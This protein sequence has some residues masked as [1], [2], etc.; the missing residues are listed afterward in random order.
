MMIN[1]IEN[2][3]DGLE[4]IYNGD[5]YINE[6]SISP[7]FEPG[8][9]NIPT[10]NLSFCFYNVETSVVN[11]RETDLRIELIKTISDEGYCC[12]LFKDVYNYT[13]GAVFKVT[14]EDGGN[15]Q[16]TTPQKCLLLALGYLAESLAR[17]EFAKRLKR[18]VNINIYKQEDVE[19]AK[20]KG[21]KFYAYYC[22][23]VD[24]HASD[25]NGNLGVLTKKRVPR[26]FNQKFIDKFLSDPANGLRK[27]TNIDTFVRERLIPAL[28]KEWA[29]L[30]V[31]KV[32][33]DKKGTIWSQQ[34]ITLEGIRYL[35]FHVSWYLEHK[36]VKFKK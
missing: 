13:R 21:L 19:I 33:S 36:F 24:K 9:N 4:F 20:E 6:L 29:A 7:K 2:E 32:K 30:H 3:L 35:K 8:L 11:N 10:D 25:Y 22:L 16:L 23:S 5:P 26:E 17:E 18:S 15:P 27:N 28:K 31:K 14:L 12:G 1:L 34:E